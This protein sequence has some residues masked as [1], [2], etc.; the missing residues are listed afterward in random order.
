MFSYSEIENSFDGIEHAACLRGFETTIQ[1]NMSNLTGISGCVIYASCAQ[2][3][4]L[5][6]QPNYG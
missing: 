5:N 6:L 4:R 1:K 3:N 2:I